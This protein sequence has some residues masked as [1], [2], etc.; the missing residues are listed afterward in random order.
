M[1]IA[2]DGWGRGNPRPH[3]VNI[4]YMSTNKVKIWFYNLAMSLWPSILALIAGLSI[5]MLVL[6]IGKYNAPVVL[7][8]S[9][10]F[11]LFTK[12]GI[13]N[14]IAISTPLLLTALTWAVGVRTGVFNISAEGAVQI[15][16]VIAI[17]TGGLVVL[18]AYVHH[19]ITVL[20][21]ICAG[22]LWT[23]PLG[24][25]K[26]KRNV[27]EVV[28]SIMLNWIAFFLASFLVVWPLRDPQWPMRS[29]KVASSARLGALVRGSTVS[30]VSFLAL[31]MSLFTYI[32][33]WHTKLGQH[34]RATGF[35]IQAARTCGIASERAVLLSFAVGGASAGLAGY[36]LTAGLPPLWSVSEKLGTLMGYGFTGICVAAVGRDHP[37]GLIA[38]SV[39]IG[40]LLASR[41][42]MQMFF[43]IAPE[44]TDAITGIIIVVLAIPELSALIRKK[45]LKKS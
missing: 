20:S 1:K 43:Q 34:M 13:L 26:N 24:I 7:A 37:I 10:N 30:S 39:V 9:L 36:A 27:N 22:I 4:N 32:L 35:N 17:A 18:P 40:A 21:A 25:I 6:W 2:K 38:S 23:I 45:L 29:I 8:R 44:I 28:S 12:Q 3:C 14:T 15:S 33:L 11:A 19:P 16:G 41:T 31:G 5:A 42:Y